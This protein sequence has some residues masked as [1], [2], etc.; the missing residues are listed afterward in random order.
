MDTHLS[1]WTPTKV[2]GHLME[3]IN[4][5]KTSPSQFTFSVVTLHTK[6]DRTILSF[7]RRPH[8]HPSPSQLQQPYQSYTIANLLL[9]KYTLITWNTVSLPCLQRTSNTQVLIFDYYSTEYLHHCGFQV[10]DP[11]PLWLQ[12]YQELFSSKETLLSKLI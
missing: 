8:S 2:Y 7:G 1:I 5:P 11:L 3:E 12:S 10:R 9:D 6:S 4:P